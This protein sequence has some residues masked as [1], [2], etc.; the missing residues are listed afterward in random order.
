MAHFYK[1]RAQAQAK[2]PAIPVKAKW[3][4]ITAGLPFL[5]HT[6]AWLNQA[7]LK[8]FGNLTKPE[9]KDKPMMI[10][11][12]DDYHVV[13]YLTIEIPWIAVLLW[14]STIAKEIHYQRYA[15][16]LN[17]IAALKPQQAL[18][19]ETTRSTIVGA[20][21]QESCDVRYNRDPIN[22]AGRNLDV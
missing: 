7:F 17:W 11:E 21:S 22:F 2:R 18:G 19:A 9:A 14:N 3:R 10:P 15:E 13:L 16:A 4:S 1:N 8:T 12:M 20:A 6:R 5:T